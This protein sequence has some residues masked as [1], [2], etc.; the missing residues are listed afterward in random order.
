MIGTML[1]GA[2]ALI[3]APAV[4]GLAWRN[5]RQRHQQPEHDT[6]LGGQ[7][8]GQRVLGARLE[9]ARSEKNRL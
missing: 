7:Q 2:A 3:A 5:A 6:C 8:T 1:G 9:S 4:G